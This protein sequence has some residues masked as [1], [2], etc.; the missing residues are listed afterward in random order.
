MIENYETLLEALDE[1]SETC[2][3]EY[4]RKAVGFHAFIGKFSTF[5]GL[6]LAH[7]VFSASEQLS[8]TLQNKDT[9]TQDANIAVNL[10]KAF[11]IR[12]RDLSKLLSKCYNKC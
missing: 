10:A 12:Q 4:G 2:K 9:T 7:L 8:I 3:D 5:F 1:I 6:K 11:Y